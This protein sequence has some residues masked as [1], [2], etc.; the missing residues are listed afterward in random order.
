MLVLTLPYS[1]VVDYAYTQHAVRSVASDF[2]LVG[3]RAGLVVLGFVGGFG[4]QL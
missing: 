1:K 3:V 4:S 2:L